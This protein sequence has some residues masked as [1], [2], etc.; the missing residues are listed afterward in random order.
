MTV[1][2]AGGGT[3]GHLYPAIAIADALRARG[4]RVTFIGSADRLE[5]SI[6]PKAGFPLQTIAAAP[7]PRRPSLAFLRAAT[8][9]VRGTLQSLHLLAAARPDIVVTTGGYVSFPVALAAR[10]QRAARRSVAPIVLFE[11][12][13][14]PGLTT[15]LLAPMADEIWGECGG[16]SARL[17]SKCRPT[18]IPVRSSLRCLP[19][20]GEA[21]ARLG[22]DPDRATLLVLGGSQ[23]ARAINDALV[24]AWS[25]NAVPAAWQVLALTGAAQYEGVASA[26]RAS[27]QGAA[28][29]VIRPYLDDMADAYALADLV[30]ARAGASTLGELAAL[31]KPA[32]L[33]PYPYATE[34]H[35]AANARRFE[36]SGAARVAT[37]AELGAGALSALLSEVTQPARLERLRAGAKTLQGDDPLE[38]ILTRIDLL[39]RGKSKA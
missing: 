2:F 15:R 38:R 8:R 12:N 5:G 34:A 6:V 11:P 3:G 35:Q 7:L 23:G 37:D 26:L 36:S 21:A 25:E 19:P 29:I 13:A 33:V 14:A 16:F 4:A 10:L 9:N 17:R 32:I 31:A 24:K 27:R 22:L 39:T 18:G 28:P 1:V 20:R 30:L